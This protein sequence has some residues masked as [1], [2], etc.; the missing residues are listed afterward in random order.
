MLVG[1]AAWQDYVLG[2]TE[3]TLASSVE[4]AP[5]TMYETRWHVMAQN[6]VARN[7][8]ALVNYIARGEPSRTVMGALINLSADE[9]AGEAHYIIRELQIAARDWYAVAGFMSRPQKGDWF[10]TP[11]E[12][13]YVGPV[14]PIA[15]AG[16]DVK[17][18]VSIE[19][20][21]HRR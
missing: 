4:I 2:D 16:V 11:E 19:G 10:E 13:F 7:G 21:P 6:M 18:K 17:Y 15:R 12:T 14:H 3:P 8:G 9:T 1:G 5:N 20:A